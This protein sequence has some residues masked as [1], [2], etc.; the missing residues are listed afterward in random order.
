MSVFRVTQARL[1]SNIA[2]FEVPAAQD[3]EVGE[4]VTVAGCTTSTFN[5]A[6]TVLTT[7]L[8]AFPVTGSSGAGTSQ[9]WS[10]FSATLTHADIPAE[11]EPSMATATQ[12]N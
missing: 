10:G 4:S 5:T 6:L 11:A 1:T 8:F 9:L 7:G 2:Y 12:G 3:W